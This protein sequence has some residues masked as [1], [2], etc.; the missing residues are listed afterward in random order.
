MKTRNQTKEWRT[1]AGCAGPQHVLHNTI[2]RRATDDVATS[3]VLIHCLFVFVFLLAGVSGWLDVER[4]FCGRNQTVPRPNTSKLCCLHAAC[5]YICCCFVSLQAMHMGMV[6]SLQHIIWS[7]F[8][9]MHKPSIVPLELQVRS[10]NMHVHVLSSM[11]METLVF[12]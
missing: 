6:T 12:V 8:Q 2:L 10:I 5:I 1:P 3:N 4:F 7:P 9:V 11:E